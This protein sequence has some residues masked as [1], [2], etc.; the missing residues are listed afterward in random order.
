MS[1]S[2]A[3]LLEQSLGRQRLQPGSIVNARVV[4]IDGEVVVVNAGLK[5]EGIIPAREFRG[6][7]GRLTVQVGDEV[8]VAL[9]MLE[10]G[11]GETVLSREEARLAK[12]WA[13]LENA[14]E[15]SEA[16]TGQLTEKVKGGFTVM[17][18]DIRAF[19]PGSLV[20]IRP[21]RDVGYLEGRESQFKI[22]KLDRRRN[23]VVVSRRAVLEAEYMEER[24]ALVETLQEGQIKQGI[25]KNLTEYGAFVDLGGIDGLLHITDMAW[26]RVRHPSEVVKVGDELTVK[27]LKFDRER[28]RVSLGLKQL[29][30]D[31]W[32]N[33]SRRYPIATQLAGT[34]TNVT[35]YGCFVEIEDGVEGL[36]HMSEMDWT[37]RNVQPSKLVQP[38]DPV[39][40]MILDVDEERRRIS[41]GMKQCKVNPWQEFAATHKKG[42]RVR[43]RIKSITDF[44]IFVELEG[45]ID[46]LVHLTD[47]SWEKPGEEAI[48]DFRKGEE[49]EAVVLLVDA[50]RERISLSIKQI[51]DEPLAAY[52]AEHPRGSRVTGEVTAVEPRF[53][54]VRLAD[55]IEATLKAAELAAKGKDAS[56]ILNVGDAVEAMIIGVDAKTRTLQLSQRAHELPEESAASE[57][58]RAAPVTGTT[59]LGELLK[60]RL[61]EA[62]RGGE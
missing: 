51:A 48:R 10:D 60:E 16:I 45:G 19:L 22:I 55:G 44:G 23:N 8:E 12:Q 46:G 40:V 21:V 59:N 25:V 50:E 61:S 14:F 49:V 24:R 33:I 1:E 54:T 7:D 34:V 31:P 47:I 43:G 5:S 11:Y 32:V 3:E 15:K 52:L 42:D 28:V 20:D 2:F 18:E 26:K 53:A 13:V 17:L 41:L 29:S 35:D 37:N 9:K 62:Q 58:Q 56:A 39:D 6:E 4:D 57:D 30:E 27:V 38:G 36:V